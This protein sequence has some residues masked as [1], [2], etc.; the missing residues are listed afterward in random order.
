MSDESKPAS[1]ASGPPSVDNVQT[2]DTS[3]RWLGYVGRLRNLVS[4]GQRY[5]AYTSDVGEAFRPV[6]HP[7]LVNVA[8]TVSFAYVAFDIGFETFK[9]QRRGDTKEE[10]YRTSLQ[11]TL[12][13]GLASLVL[14]AITIHTVVD[15]SGKVLKN[16]SS[17]LLRKWGPTS[18]GLAVIP[19]LPVLL[20]H[21]VEIAL[22]YVFD[23]LWP[24]SEEA[25]Q[26]AIAHGVHQHQH[27]QQH[28][29]QQQSSASGSET[30]KS[31]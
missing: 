27:N 28:Q 19:T 20:D 29:Q 21:P 11:R 22:D 16:A 9:S 7:L 17:A 31:Q 4:V 30:K 18:V 10:I 5:L 26:R 13:Q 23:Q 6:V 25:R 24:L 15:M 3:L 1:Q 14:P 2:T 12:F 8:Y